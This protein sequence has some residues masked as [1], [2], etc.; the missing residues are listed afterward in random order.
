VKANSSGI[1]SRQIFVSDQVSWDSTGLRHS[2]E[3][4]PASPLRGCGHALPSPTHFETLPRSCPPPVR[5]PDREWKTRPAGVRHILWMLLA[6]ARVQSDFTSPLTLEILTHAKICSVRNQFAPQTDK[7]GRRAR[8]GWT[9]Q[10]QFRYL[11]LTP[12]LGMLASLIFRRSDVEKAILR[13]ATRSA[14]LE[15]G[16]TIENAQAMAAHELSRT[17]VIKEKCY[18]QA[19]TSYCVCRHHRF[20]S[21]SG[22]DLLYV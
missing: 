10:G 6:T 22:T 21:K 12:R 3:V 9:T 19:S 20:C 5:R 1:E 7:L 11:R 13:A 8:R 16:G 17:T 15:H 4:A 14:Y 2:V 18:D